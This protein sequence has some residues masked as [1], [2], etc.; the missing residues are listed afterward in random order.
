MRRQRLH[1][2]GYCLEVLLSNSRS[3]G[4]I[5]RYLHDGLVDREA[6][7][8][9]LQMV[10]RSSPTFDPDSDDVT[11]DSE[12]ARLLARIPLNIFSA[13]ISALCEIQ[14]N[15][16]PTRPRWRSTRVRFI[17]GA[18]KCTLARLRTAPDSDVGP[19][20]TILRALSRPNI[21]VS[22]DNLTSELYP[23][24]NRVKAAELFLWVYGELRRRKG[25]D[26]VMFD[27]LCL[28]LR[29]VMSAV[30]F[31]KVARK[32][33][34]GQVIE[35]AHKLIKQAFKIIT[36]PSTP[37]PEM[38]DER[39]GA[40]SF[41]LGL[42]PLFHR[43]G[44]VH[45][46]NYIRTLGYLGDVDEM[47]QAAEWM[48]NNWGAS[49]FEQSRNPSHAHHGR[50]VDTLA[51]FRAFA[52][53]QLSPERMAEL[54]ERMALLVDQSGGQLTWP[55]RQE[56]DT[57]ASR[58]AGREL[59]ADDSVKYWRR[60]MARLR[61]DSGARLSEGWGIMEKDDQQKVAHADGCAAV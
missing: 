20:H 23:V 14:P 5:H 32:S 36:Q 55:T 57:Y 21:V 11:A 41:D 51:M 15:H 52:E 9:F 10:N 7:A 6:I 33:E 54:D 34:A 45:L 3:L 35:K 58:E 38:D 37:V 8:A 49:T 30:E 22:V 2:V 40:R 56:A 48:V 16:N 60:T 46:Q 53:L 61:L 1:P 42:P 19:W 28:M 26:V 59:K 27:R 18:V 12:A 17:P 29:R 13:C 39:R 47:T 31:R 4:Y 24:L 50:A 44:V 43:V 25:V